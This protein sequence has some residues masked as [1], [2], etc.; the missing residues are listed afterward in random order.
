MSIVQELKDSNEFK[1]FIK[2][3][4]DNNKVLP[5]HM[6]TI[7][8][9]P[10]ALIGELLAYLMDNYK[11]AITPTY[12][13][14]TCYYI[15]RDTKFMVLAYIMQDDWAVICSVESILLEDVNSAMLNYEK[16]IVKLFN[17]LDSNDR[18]N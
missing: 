7:L 16:A 18:H 1:K 11:I 10:E 3:L 15:T 9:L 14:Y 4:I 2:Y 13:S 8:N 17:M 12:F 5:A 6:A